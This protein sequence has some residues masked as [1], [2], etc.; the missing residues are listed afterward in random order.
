MSP[1]VIRCRG[2]LKPAAPPLSH[3]PSGH[4]PFL[5]SPTLPIPSRKVYFANW[6]MWRSRRWSL[7]DG[8]SRQG[9]SF[10]FSPLARSTSNQQSGQERRDTPTPT[11]ASGSSSSWGA[12]APPS[13]SSSSWRPSVCW[14]ATQTPPYKQA[15]GEGAPPFKQAAGEGAKQEERQQGSGPT[16]SP[17]FFSTPASRGA[18]RQ[19]SGLR[20]GKEP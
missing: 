20:V 10:R 11:A 1:I 3:G 8:S 7:D 4:C 18:V 15:A 17:T 2:W 16:T 12:W 19:R 5:F 9:G 14:S 6:G 13:T